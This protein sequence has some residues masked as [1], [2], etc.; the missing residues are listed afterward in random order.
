MNQPPARSAARLIAWGAANTQVFDP[1]QLVD[2]NVEMTPALAALSLLSSRRALWEI[3]AL[4]VGFA[5]D[6]VGEADPE[7]VMAELRRKENIRQWFEDDDFLGYTDDVRDVETEPA[8]LVIA[9][10]IIDSA[11]A[12]DA[13][14]SA[15]FGTVK[16]EYCM[17]LC[18]DDQQCLLRCLTS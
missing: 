1:P 2:L 9:A 14:R 11:I 4:I 8:G 7:R 3:H 16:I 15:Q 18:D 17:K 13:L 6:M 5:M 10:R 12:G